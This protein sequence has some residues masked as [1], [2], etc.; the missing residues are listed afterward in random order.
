MDAYKSS[1]SSP[2]AHPD[3]NRQ[4]FQNLKVAARKT[5]YT[6]QP[7]LKY[8][9]QYTEKPF[10]GILG[11]LLLTTSAA[12]E[13]YNNLELGTYYSRIRKTQLFDVL[14]SVLF[15]ANIRARK[16]HGHITH[17]TGL[18]ESSKYDDIPSRYAMIQRVI[19]EASPVKLSGIYHLLAQLRENGFST[20]L[21]TYGSK[22]FRIL[23][24]T[25]LAE[26]A[27]SAM[28]LGW[29]SIANPAVESEDEVTS[30]ETEETEETSDDQS[31]ESSSID[32]DDES[33]FSSS[34]SDL[35]SLNDP[36][37]SSDFDY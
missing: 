31:K 14:K 10:F 37:D 18:S 1:D 8:D 36:D 3:S 11:I 29:D 30:D 16:I 32:D 20:K 34:G 21:G 13:I 28:G 35:P 2:S 4:K 24:E 33:I 6:L 19:G 23:K 26:N 27:V 25:A 7:W 9:L 5:L 22:L 15:D 12:E 17:I